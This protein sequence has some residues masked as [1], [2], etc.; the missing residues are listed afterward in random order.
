M[1]VGSGLEAGP[2]DRTYL[3]A[4][5]VGR[6]GASV[7]SMVPKYP[8]SISSHVCSPHFTDA[9]GSGL[10]RF[11]EELSKCAT[12]IS[13]E[14]AG[15]NLGSASLYVSCQLKSYFGTRSSTSSLPSG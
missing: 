6:A 5:D 14:P 13:V 1:S 8:I 4:A 3:P 10:K 9:V 11:A 7:F 12:I 2:Q 15:R